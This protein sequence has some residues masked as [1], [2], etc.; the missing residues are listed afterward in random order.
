LDHL[1]GAEL[2]CLHFEGQG[3]AG[4]HELSGLFHIFEFI[5]LFAHETI[6][7]ANC[8]EE[9]AVNVLNISNHSKDESSHHL[10]DLFSF[11]PLERVFLAPLV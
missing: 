4:E 6:E 10:Q 8:F 7:K 9:E 3:E 1:L 11:F 2:A 5:L